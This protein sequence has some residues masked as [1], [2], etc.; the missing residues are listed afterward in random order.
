MGNKLQ[1]FEYYYKNYQYCDLLKEDPY[2]VL[3]INCRKITGELEEDE[4]GNPI[5]RK[6]L[7]TIDRKTCLLH[8]KD[9]SMKAC[10]YSTEH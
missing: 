7:P 4:H 9:I 3:E 8:Y 2:Q 5:K 10:K 6:Y 1:F